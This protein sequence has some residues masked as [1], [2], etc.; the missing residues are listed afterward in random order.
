MKRREQFLKM[1]EACENGA[2]DLILTK[3]ISRFARNT[4]DSVQ[5]LRRLKELNVEVFFQKENIWTSRSEG[6]F[7]ITLL[8]SLAQEESRSVSQNTTWG[9]RKK[10]S[11]GRYSVGYSRFLGYDKNMKVNPEEADVVRQFYRLYLEGFSSSAISP[12][13]EEQGIPAPA[14]GER[15]SD[16]TIL[17][18]LGN[19]KYK[20]DALLQQNYT[21][22]F[23][24]KTVKK[25]TGELN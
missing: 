19:I 15:W 24:T 17:S 21:S 22:D 18:I 12:I 8:S 3:S 25:N 2:I 10:F 14:G 1:M 13:L 16:S 20:G 7:L 6:E 11:E 9:I 23:I 4:V 5:M